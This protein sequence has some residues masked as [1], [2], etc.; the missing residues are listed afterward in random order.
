MQT[1]SSNSWI[2]GQMHLAD[3]NKYYA[4]KQ[5]ESQRKIDDGIRERIKNEKYI[6]VYAEDGYYSIKCI[7]QIMKGLLSR[8][9]VNE[10]VLF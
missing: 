5:N 10:T 8:C 9:E 3:H 4:R 1:T 2:L 7:F 6:A